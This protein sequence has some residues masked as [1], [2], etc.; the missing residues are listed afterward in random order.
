MVAHEGVRR[1]SSLGG[2]C[3]S[4]YATLTV[5]QKSRIHLAFRNATRK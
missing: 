3:R 4:H 1:D 2:V 5:S